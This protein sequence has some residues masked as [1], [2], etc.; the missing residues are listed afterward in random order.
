MKK[1]VRN[2]IPEF[3]T[4]AKY[5]KLKPEEIEA[6]LKNKIV[7]EAQEVK[8]APNEENLIEELGDMYTVLQAFLEFKKIDESRFLKKVEEKN[9]A[10]GTFSEYL[11]METEDE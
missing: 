4:Y 1:L 7:E 11:L 8:A 6:A 3:A 2:K 10:K 5:R 9:R